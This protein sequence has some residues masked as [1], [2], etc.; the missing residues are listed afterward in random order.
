M[1]TIFYVMLISMGVIAILMMAATIVWLV[2]FKLV[3]GITGNVKDT[4]KTIK[5]PSRKI[6]EIRTSW[7]DKDGVQHESVEVIK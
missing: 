1:A 6:K 3:K 7:I 2:V 5:E 4:V